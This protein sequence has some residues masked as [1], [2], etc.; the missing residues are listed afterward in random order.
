MNK[1]LFV[2]GL[3]IAVIAA[4]LLVLDIIESGVAALIGIVGIGIIAASGRSKMKRME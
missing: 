1:T 2:I 4:A 3:L